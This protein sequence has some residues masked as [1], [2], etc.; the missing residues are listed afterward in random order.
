MYPE[1][2]HKPCATGENYDFK[3]EQEVDSLGLDV[4]QQQQQQQ[5]GGY[6]I[7][8]ANNTYRLTTE[9]EIVEYYHAAAGWPVKKTWIVAIQHNTYSS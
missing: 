4:Q 5:Q 8:L 9:K 6:I 7:H 3:K 2:G 1:K